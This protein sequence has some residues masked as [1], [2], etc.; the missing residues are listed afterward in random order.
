MDPELVGVHPPPQI[1][2]SKSFD[3]F[4]PIGPCIVSAE[5]RLKSL[6]N[7]ESRVLISL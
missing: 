7:L 4:C 6:H 1:S 3:G 2:F 5:V